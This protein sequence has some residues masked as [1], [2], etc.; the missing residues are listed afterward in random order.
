MS[1]FGCGEGTNGSVHSRFKPI[2]DGV[3][4]ANYSFMQGNSQYKATSSDNQSFFPSELPARVR[5]EGQ[6][7]CSRGNNSGDLRGLE[8]VNGGKM[9]FSTSERVLRD[10]VSESI[11]AMALTFQEFTEEVITSIKEHLKGLIEMP[12]KKGELESLQ[13]Q[14]VPLFEQELVDCDTTQN[15]GRNGGLMESAFEFI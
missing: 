5:F 8:G 7:E 10:I 4:L 2:G 14:L 3:A 13:N 15:Q 9:Q 12:E 6:S 11:P 1:T